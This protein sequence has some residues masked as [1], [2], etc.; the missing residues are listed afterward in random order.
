MYP[1]VLQKLI[2]SFR[3]LPGV[4]LK[5]AER[6]AFEILEI[7]D[8]EAKDFIDSII[9][10]RTKL[11]KCRICA[12]LS[13]DDECLICK[14]K[15]RDHNIICVVQHPKDIIAME[16]IQEYHGVYHV[17]GGVIATSKGILP[18]D[19]NITSLLERVNEDTK[20]VIVATNPTLEGETT[21]MYLA[22][23][24]ADKDIVVSRLANGLPMGGHLD[25]ADELTLSKAMEG[26]QKIK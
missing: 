3:M 18:A 1:K 22:R 17:L 13:E 14:D 15:E 19:L 12:N 16:K 8:D 21:A 7:T 23:L 20:E 26:R 9:A 2:E 6:Y 25:Y 10:C 24:L 11:K 5:T 4:G